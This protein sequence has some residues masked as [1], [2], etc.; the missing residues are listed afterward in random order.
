MK[1]FSQK[2][3]VEGAA[4]LRAPQKSFYARPLCRRAFTLIEIMV[5]LTIFMLVVAAVYSTWILILKSSAVGEE[6]AA[7]VQRERIAVRTIED[8][9]TCIQSFQASMQYYSFVVQNGDQ[10]ELSFTARLPA[11]FPRNDRFINPVTG[12][13]F[14]VRRLTFTV[15]SGPDSEKELVLRQN[16]ILMDMD[17]IEQNNPLV[18]ARDVKDFTVECWDTNTQDWATEWDDT[19]AIP[20]VIRVTLTLGGDAAPTRTIAR[21]ISVPSTTVPVQAQAPMFGGGGRPTIPPPAPP[22]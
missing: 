6:A 20:S 9:L 11:I 7:Q 18:L 2:S 4:Q 21:L 1:I 10:P 13:N 17:P 5:A 12:Q 15:E 14:P 3:K 22:R 8:S 16:P 19:N